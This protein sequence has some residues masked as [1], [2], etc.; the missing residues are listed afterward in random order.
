MKTKTVTVRE[1][2]YLGP[3]DWNYDFNQHGIT[4]FFVEQGKRVLKQVEEFLKDDPD[5]EVWVTE[6]GDFTHRVLEI[7]MYDGWP[8]WKPVPHVLLTGVLG[9]EWQVFYNLQSA[10]LKSKK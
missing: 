1:G 9:P 7:G 4:P 2:E 5:A 3:I 6:S 8:W 10:E